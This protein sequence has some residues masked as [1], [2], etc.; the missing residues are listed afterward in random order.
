[1]KVENVVVGCLGMATITVAN[2]ITEVF[3]KIFNAICQ[4][5]GNCVKFCKSL[6]IAI[7][8]YLM[9]YAIKGVTALKNVK[10]HGY[11]N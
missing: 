5:S 4:F 10:R 2:Q 7:F 3:F 11:E 8:K 1:M 6:Q 9:L